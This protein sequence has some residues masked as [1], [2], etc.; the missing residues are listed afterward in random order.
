M[1]LL[2][3][4]CPPNLASRPAQRPAPE[5]PLFS[6]LL[7]WLLA[8]GDDIVPIPGTTRIDRLEENAAADRI[9][10]TDGQI[11][12]LDNLTP[13]TGDRYDEANMAALDL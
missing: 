2:V 7:A 10:L 11:A 6:G 4:G 1:P 8:Q 3:S 9:S 12:R 13:A 5:P